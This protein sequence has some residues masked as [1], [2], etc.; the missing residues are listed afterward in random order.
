MPPYV[1]KNTNNP[2]TKP[3][4]LVVN[5]RVTKAGYDF[6]KMLN[7]YY[8]AGRM[9]RLGRLGHWIGLLF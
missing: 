7:V 1:N 8:K 6:L 3:N 2:I 5:G 4:Y 9:D